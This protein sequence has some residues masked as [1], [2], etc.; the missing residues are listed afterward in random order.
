EGEVTFAFGNDQTAVLDL[1][2]MEAVAVQQVGTATLTVSQAATDN[3]E[4][5][6]VSLEVTVTPK[7]ITIVPMA[8]QGKVYGTAE[9]DS[10]GYT[11]A[12]DES[13]AFDDE[14]TDIVSAS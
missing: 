6:S 4:E 12:E 14:L 11:L 7:A 10:Y 9:P 2:D 13:L 3:Y 1:A 8:S 5:A